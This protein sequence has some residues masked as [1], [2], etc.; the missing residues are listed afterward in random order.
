M[1]AT[2]VENDQKQF[3]VLDCNP[4]AVWKPVSF[5]DMFIEALNDSA[6]ESWLTFPL[7]ND[8][9]TNSMPNPLNFDGV[10]ITGSHYNIRDGVTLPWFIDL[11]QLVRLCFDNGRPALY[12]GCFGCQIIAHALGG[13]VGFNKNGRFIC[14]V[15]NVIPVL[16][17]R[18]CIKKEEISDDAIEETVYQV[19]VSHGDCVLELPPQATLLAT[20]SSCEN[21]IFMIG[22]SPDHANILACQSHPEFEVNYCIWD[23]IWP[24]AVIQR[25]RLTAEEKILYEPGFRSFNPEN[26]ANQLLN[27]I[28]KFLHQ[29]LLN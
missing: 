29:D 18:S 4:S 21:E 13:K 25:Q 2:A 16:P 20:S 26:G 10:V 6:Y 12:G 23:R 19:I 28:K 3:C 22:K 8:Y 7:N 17:L 27:V 14:K 1:N 9:I 5:A 24:I 15:E 11:I